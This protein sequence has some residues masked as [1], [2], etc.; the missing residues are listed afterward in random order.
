[1]E[2]NST[3]AIEARKELIAGADQTE[4]QGQESTWSFS[5]SNLEI[6]DLNSLMEQFERIVNHAALHKWKICMHIRDKFQSDKLMGQFLNTYRNE[7]PTHPL[8]V[9]SQ[10]DIN[11]YGN[12]GRFC[13]KHGINS[14]ES[15]GIL[16][17]NIYEL[18]RPQNGDFADDI[19]AKIKG[20]KASVDDVKRMIKQAKAV[21]T[22]EKSEKEGVAQEPIDCEEFPEISRLSN[23]TDL[24]ENELYPLL[25]EYLKS[26]HNLKCYRIDEKRSGN[27]HKGRNHWLHPDIVAMEPVDKNWNP[28][29]RQSSGQRARLWSFEVK[30]ELTVSN[31][32]ECFFQAVSNSS[33]ADEG[34]LVAADIT[35]KVVQEL[36]ILSPA[37]HIGVIFLDTVNP[38]KSQ[39]LLSAKPRAN[40][41]EPD[42]ASVNRITEENEDFKDFMKEVS[43]YK[44]TGHV[45][46]ITWL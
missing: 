29:V 41:P 42:W 34:Y 28:L 39:I 5:D 13:A 21:F 12:A 46:D 27:Q 3:S 14:L 18:S 10:Q 30:T 26:E 11:R 6:M 17:S 16:I 9:A 23:Y 44:M 19:Y 33:W 45:S 8:S 24:S 31:V 20:K 43:A 7:H 22:I 35:D 15:A 2:I 37:Y 32:R 36:R 40:R 4:L 38:S 25:A 1:M